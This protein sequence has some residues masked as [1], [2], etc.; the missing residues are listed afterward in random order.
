[1]RRS[2]LI[3]KITVLVLAIVA[4]VSQP[5]DTLAYITSNSNTVQNSFNIVYQ[6]PKDIVV[7][8]WIQKK[9]VNLSEWEMGADGFYFHLR[10][11]ETGEKILLTSLE[12]GRAYAQ[13]I[14]TAADVGKTHHYC[15]YELNTGREYV[16]YDTAVYEIEITL[17]LNE[18]NEISADIRLNGEAVTEICAAFENLYYVPV[19][20]PETGD[21]AKPLLWTA[22]FIFSAFGLFIF[23]KKHSACRRI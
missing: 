18:I 16:T 22:M 15:L 4:V 2:G 19:V 20:P 17:G 14:F 12:D 7:P 8:V 5:P 9:I 11:V 21:S 6:P 13:L 1:M 3:I 23:S 10:N